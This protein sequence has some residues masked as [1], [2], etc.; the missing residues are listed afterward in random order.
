MPK[1]INDTNIAT[2][3]EV[4]QHHNASVAA[5]FYSSVSGVNVQYHYYQWNIILGIL[6]YLNS[7]YINVYTHRVPF[8]SITGSKND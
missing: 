4:K 7:L 2:W 3:F 6:N 1:D 5:L 8:K